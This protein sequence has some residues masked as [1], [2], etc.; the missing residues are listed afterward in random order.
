METK[1]KMDCKHRLR[2]VSER[3]YK[4]LAHSVE[5]KMETLLTTEARIRVKLKRS[6][7]S[8]VNA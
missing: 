7:T 2:H 1:F 8:T 5:E 4:G 3:K 6:T